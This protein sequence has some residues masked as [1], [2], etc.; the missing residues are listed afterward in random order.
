MTVCD[1]SWVQI[2][3]PSQ[4]YL[5][6]TKN[7]QKN[8]T[9]LAHQSGGHFSHC[10]QFLLRN[11]INCG[12]HTH[13]INKSVNQMYFLIQSAVLISLGFTC[14]LSFYSF[15]LSSLHAVI[16]IPTG[17]VTNPSISSSDL[18]V[19]YYPFPSPLQF[20]C[21]DQNKYVKPNIHCNSQLMS[22]LS[23]RPCNWQESHYTVRFKNEITY[24]F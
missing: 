13:L 15:N 2:L 20:A 18:M 8:I 19:T 16:L 12:E 9:V 11:V 10:L 22:V 7:G 24:G 23:L 1:T 5:L 3:P 6:Q 4:C 21:P 17:S 14:R